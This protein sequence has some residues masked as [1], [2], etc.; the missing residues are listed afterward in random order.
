[1]PW[2]SNLSLGAD[3]LSS[4]LGYLGFLRFSLLNLS[5]RITLCAS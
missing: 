2:A 3:L 5:F 4:Q 1:M